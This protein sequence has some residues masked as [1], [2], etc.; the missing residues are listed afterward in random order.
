MGSLL[1]TAFEALGRPG[2]LE[3]L[4]E[5]VTYKF[6]PIGAAPPASDKVIQ[7]IVCPQEERLDEASDGRVLI[8]SRLVIFSTD[9]TDGIPDPQIRDRIEIEG[10]TWEL[11]QPEL[12]QGGMI[13]VNVVRA[14]GIEVNHEG[15]R[16]ARRFL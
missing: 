5:P 14:Q 1:D 16:R 11:E 10:E 3:Q 15:Y 13:R 12:D 6:A 7:A 8:R 9:A 4:A 2:L